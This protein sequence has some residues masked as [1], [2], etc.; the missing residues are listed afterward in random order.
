M[1]EKK[2][3]RSMREKSTVG[4]ANVFSWSG[5]NRSVNVINKTDTNRR[6]YPIMQ[7]VIMT[8]SGLASNVNGVKKK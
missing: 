1:H 2:E 5:V 4:D 8:K 6:P 7:W 3:R